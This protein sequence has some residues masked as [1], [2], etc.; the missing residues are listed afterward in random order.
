MSFAHPL[1]ALVAFSIA[2]IA[3]ASAAAALRR[4]ALAC[5]RYSSLP[6]LTQ[7][8]QAPRWPS[9]ALT[10]SAALG[11]LLLVA[12][13]GRPRIAIALP[14]RSA[15]LMICIDTSGSMRTADVRPTRAMAALRAARAVARGV[16]SGVAVGV[17]TFSNTAELLL[18]PSIDRTRAEA[19]FDAVPPPNGPTAIGDALQLARGVLPAHGGAIVLITDGANNAGSD[20][21]IAVQALRA[22]GVRLY[23]LGIGAADQPV[24]RAFASA[25]GGAY[26]SAG[27]AAGV[28]RAMGSLARA[29]ISVRRE[30]DLGLPAALAGGVVLAVTL[31]A[32]VCAGRWP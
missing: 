18:A 6:L 3:C 21:H 22:R 5:V 19:A 14:E 2:A 15:A 16:P 31:F 20:P 9:R 23:A 8:L 32:G 13:A 26:R 10:A 7:A 27:D 11:V 24:L 17:V 12:A 29:A 30:R 4:N 25:T 28:A 1:V